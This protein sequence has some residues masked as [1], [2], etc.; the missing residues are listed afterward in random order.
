M[1]NCCTGTARGDNILKTSLLWQVLSAKRWE[2]LKIMCG[3]LLLSIRE[4][5]RRLDRDVKAVHGDV[6]ALLDAGVLDRTPN[7]MVEFPRRSESRVRC[8]RQRNDGPSLRRAGPAQS[9]DQRRRPVRLDAQRHRGPAGCLLVTARFEVGK[10][11]CALDKLF[12]TRDP[13]AARTRKT[14]RSRRFSGNAPAS[15]AA[16]AAPH[17]GAPPSESKFEACRRLAKFWQTG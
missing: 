5:A 13:S 4:A 11:H 9:L 17:L 1:N 14:A 16:T 3:A 8:C 6:K 12:C 2:L 15:R 10:A 7:G